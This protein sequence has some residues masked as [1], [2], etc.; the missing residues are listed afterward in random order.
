MDPFPETWGERACA[1]HY[2]DYHQL[3]MV[4]QANGQIDVSQSETATLVRKI[5]AAAIAIFTEYPSESGLKL[6]NMELSHVSWSERP[7]RM[8]YYG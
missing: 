1:H 4:H 2:T 7:F 6:R 8:S 5:S 3:R